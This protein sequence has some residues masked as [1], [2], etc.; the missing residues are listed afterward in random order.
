MYR[1]N[2]FA[3]GNNGLAGADSWWQVS[4]TRVEP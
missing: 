3:A 1:D 4:V 2:L